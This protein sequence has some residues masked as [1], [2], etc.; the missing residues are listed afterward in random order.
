[1]LEEEKKVR[2]QQ[3]NTCTQK[4]PAYVV[5][6]KTVVNLFTRQ[7]KFIM[8]TKRKR[9]ILSIKDKQS[10][11]LRLGHPNKI[12]RLPSPDRPIFLRKVKKEFKIHQPKKKIL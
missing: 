8:S 7:I 3:D 5:D 9:S 12:F 6:K 1:M 10:I 2:R 4:R 11:I